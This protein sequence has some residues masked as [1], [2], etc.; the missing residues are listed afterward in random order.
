MSSIKCQH[1]QLFYLLIHPV[2]MHSPRLLSR[3]SFRTEIFLSEINAVIDSSVRV[4]LAK[5]GRHLATPGRGSAISQ[6]SEL[7]SVTFPKDLL[8]SASFIKSRTR[9][10]AVECPGSCSL[11]T[12]FVADKRQQG[13][14]DRL[15]SGTGANKF[16]AKTVH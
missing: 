10:G 3:M 12:L 1:Q 7:M 14:S 4:C 6:T 2:S 9:T 5:H 15:R 16:M 11:G 8:C 13:A